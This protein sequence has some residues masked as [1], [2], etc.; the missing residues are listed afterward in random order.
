MLL[1]FE[2]AM[3]AEEKRRLMTVY[4]GSNR[5][6]AGEFYPGV[7]AEEAVQRV[8][9][10]FC[11]FLDQ[12][13]ASPQNTCYVW[14]EDG[15]WVSALRLTRLP[16]FYYMEA[17]ET[18]PDRRRRGCAERL[19][20]AVSEY[21][22]QN[23]RRSSDSTET[24]TVVIRSCVSKRNAPSLA[25]HRKCGFTIDQDPA[26]GYYADPPVENPRA[27]G[28]K[29]EAGAGDRQSAIGDAMIAPHP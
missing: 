9:D 15:E 21:L 13:L 5:E 29:L 19:L 10:G 23:A 20:R 4:E 27:Y 17:L 18:A 14:A 16:D 6:N 25:I 28:M 2:T 26:L 24:D 8:R 3:T 12:F 1:V 7:P 11:A 22:V